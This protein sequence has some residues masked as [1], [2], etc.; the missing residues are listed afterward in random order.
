MT[1]YFKNV[2]RQVTA[3][4]RTKKFQPR[5]P[6]VSKNVNRKI[7]FTDEAP[8]WL[9]GYVNKQNCHY[10]HGGIIA[11]YFFW[12]EAVNAVTINSQH[13]KTKLSDFFF[14]KFRWDGGPPL[15][16]HLNINTL[17]ANFDDSLIS[18]MSTKIMRFNAPRYFARSSKVS[19]R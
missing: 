18:R 3:V 4:A 7:I 9:S 19:L 2:F 10:W 13:Y 6:Y 11:P 16:S 12:N 5:G 14:A 8:F 17:H 15:V 1:L